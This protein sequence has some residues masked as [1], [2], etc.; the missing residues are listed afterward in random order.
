MVRII[1]TKTTKKKAKITFEFEHNGKMHKR[2]STLDVE[3]FSRL[4]D[5]E[6]NRHVRV[7]ANHERKK[8]DTSRPKT[9]KEEQREESE[10]PEVEE[11]SEMEKGLEQQSDLEEE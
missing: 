6:L 7:R 8:I 4:S 2:T 9:K 11:P 10:I 5:R 1:E 3:T